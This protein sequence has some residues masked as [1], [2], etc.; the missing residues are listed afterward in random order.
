[1]SRQLAGICTYFLMS[2][3]V[4]TDSQINTLAQV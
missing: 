2:L 4:R 3:T 1:V